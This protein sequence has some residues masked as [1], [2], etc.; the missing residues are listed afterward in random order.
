MS[1]SLTDALRYTEDAHELIWS[2][3]NGTRFPGDD[4]SFLALTYV[5]VAL[6]HQTSVRKLIEMNLRGSAAALLRSQVETVVRG[7]WAYSLA[8]ADEVYA[9]GQKGGEPFPK[10]RDMV[11]AVDREL[12][13]VP[14]FALLAGGWKIL[15][16]YTHTGMEQ[17]ASRVHTRIDGNIIL[18]PSYS[19]ESVEGILHVS[20]AISLLF[21]MAIFQW[22]GFPEKAQALIEWSESHQVD[23]ASL[24]TLNQNFSSA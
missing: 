5:S 19:S 9:I 1:L 6:E 2:Q 3:I 15:N 17:L 11:T 4:R 16:I 8:T 13:T 10:F 23:H 12:G 22:L 24:E 20:G 14:T 7:L 18:S 21:L